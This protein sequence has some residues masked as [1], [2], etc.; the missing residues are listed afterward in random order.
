MKKEMINELVEAIF[1]IEEVKD[2]SEYTCDILED[3]CDCINLND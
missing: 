2:E 3:L 1:R